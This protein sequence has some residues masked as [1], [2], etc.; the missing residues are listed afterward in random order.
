M[1]ANDINESNS[2]GKIERTS[3]FQ[4]VDEY[5]GECLPL[6]KD[7]SMVSLKGNAVKLIFSGEKKDLT[8]AASAEN[9]VFNSKPSDNMSAHDI[10]NGVL[11]KGLTGGN[12]TGEISNLTTVDS[13]GETLRPGSYVD[14]GIG[15]TDE[16]SDYS[17]HS[18]REFVNHFMLDEELEI[19]HLAARKDQLSS[20]QR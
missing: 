8:E 20:A 1:E 9:D 19:E 18:P 16:Q 2:K 10:S 15:G 4:S 14:Q 12:D 3:E 5:L 7:N 6:N 11:D 17:R 13:S